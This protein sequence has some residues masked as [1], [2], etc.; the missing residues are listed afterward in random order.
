VGNTIL[1]VDN[2][3]GSLQLRDPSKH[4]AGDPR[5]KPVCFSLRGSTGGT[6]PQTVCDLGFRWA[7]AEETTEI[8]NIGPVFKRSVLF[9]RKALSFGEGDRLAAGRFAE[10]AFRDPANKTFVLDITKAFR[11]M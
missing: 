5:D 7:G 4:P 10:Q 8:I 1:L 11:M 2:P 9:H 6:V 3:H